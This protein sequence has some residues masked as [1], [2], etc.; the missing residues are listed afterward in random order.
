[1]KVN[2]RKLLIYGLVAV[3]VALGFWLGGYSYFKYSD[4]WTAAQQL[5]STSDIVVS[6]VGKVQKI[7]PSP[8]GFYYRLS[9]D[10]AEARITIVVAG[11]K[12]KA[13][14]KA[15]IGMADGRWKLARIEEQ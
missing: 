5:I 14:F 13:R 1:M 15:D 10:W 9:G 12:A 11:E 4:D 6:R 7:D 3:T 2:S 8:I